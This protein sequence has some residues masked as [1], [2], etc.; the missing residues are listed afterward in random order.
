MASTSGAGSRPQQDEALGDFAGWMALKSAPTALPNVATALSSSSGFVRVCPRTGRNPSV[1]AGRVQVDAKALHVAFESVWTA[2]Q[3]PIIPMD[4]MVEALKHGAKLPH[5]LCRW[6]DSR[7]WTFTLPA[8]TTL[9]QA[10]VAAALAAAV[11]LVMQSDVVTGNAVRET[12][13]RKRARDSAAASAV[14]QAAADERE[15]SMT[16]EERRQAW[17]AGAGPS[18]PPSPGTGSGK[19]RGK[20]VRRA[21]KRLCG[22]RRANAAGFRE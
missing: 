16:E 15:A 4:R 2:E 8:A 18:S 21:P 5:E 12:A 19:R 9:D 17:S 7:K 3:V 11:E 10:T 6:A 1:H 20:P 22:T 13:Q 14:E